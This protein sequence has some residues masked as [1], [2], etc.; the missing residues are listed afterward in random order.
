LHELFANDLPLT[1][2]RL[3]TPDM[4]IPAS[5]V[6]QRALIPTADKVV[7]ELRRLLSHK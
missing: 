5:P 6:L 2:A 1:L 4:R 3:A 7:E